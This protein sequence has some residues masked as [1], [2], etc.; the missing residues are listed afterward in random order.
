VGLRTGLGLKKRQN[1]WGL[2]G[3]SRSTERAAE[4]APVAQFTTTPTDVSDASLAARIRRAFAISDQRTSG[5]AEGMWRQL[6]AMKEDVR[7]ALLSGTDEEVAELLR[8]PERTDL[9]YGFENCTRTLLE[10]DA[11][12][13]HDFAGG[14]RLMEEQFLRLGEACGLRP[15]RHPESSR[16]PPPLD[17]ETLL[18]A[19]DEALGFRIDFPNPFAFEM[20]VA[21]S[22]G[23]ASYRAIHA[24]YQ[25]WL[26][27]QHALPGERVLEIGAGLGRAAYYA[28]RAGFRDYTIIDLPMTNV[29][30]A[31]FL[32]RVLP[33]SAV[34]LASEPEDA[35]IRIRDISWRPDRHERFAVVINADSLTEMDR[36]D[37]TSYVELA[38][39]MDATFISL[40]HE[41]NG[42]TSRELLQA[43]FPRVTRARHWLRDGYVV[44]VADPALAPMGR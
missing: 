3:G 39:A 36:A 12:S 35:P 21:T 29:A 8:H 19:L 1:G 38:A 18:R 17:I 37:A 15:A 25:V 4:G 32:G 33:S 5:G 10:R 27:A 34:A 31:D 20:G 43:R 44:E 11:R 40:N 13:G 22:R 9:L 42:F 23:I 26:L 30:Q 6:N 24:L 41:A 16:Q 28:Y 7:E 2:L 14:G